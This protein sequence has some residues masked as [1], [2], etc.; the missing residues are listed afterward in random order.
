VHGPV[1]A[2]ASHAVTEGGK[3]PTCWD[4]ARVRRDRLEDAAGRGP[5]LQAAM[6]MHP[7]LKTPRCPS[8]RH[9]D[10]AEETHLRNPLLRLSLSLFIPLLNMS[11]YVYER[12]SASISGTVRALARRDEGP[13]PASGD[14][15]WTSYDSMIVAHGEFS[16]AGILWRSKGVECGADRPLHAALCGFIAWQ[17]VAPAAVLVKMLGKRD[18]R[19]ILGVHGLVSSSLR[20][21]IELELIA[22]IHLQMQL[23]L[24]LPLTVIG[25]VLGRIATNMGN[26]PVDTHKVRR[27]LSS[28]GL[29]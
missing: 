9:F 13:S 19:T 14:G 8:H 20:K 27:T 2:G 11:P 10:S 16:S 18:N 12:V 26:K 21:V 17:I 25:V 4:G 23:C 29:R 7:L 5:H 15:G 28:L 3:E 1:G 6:S 24:T 22:L